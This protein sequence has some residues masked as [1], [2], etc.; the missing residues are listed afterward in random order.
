MEKTKQTYENVCTVVRVFTF[1]FLMIASHIYNLHAHSFP[2]D[3][4]PFYNLAAG[5]GAEACFRNI[6]VS[7]SSIM[8]GVY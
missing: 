3:Y 2:L 4:R 8:K 7:E 6:N 1:P 5:T